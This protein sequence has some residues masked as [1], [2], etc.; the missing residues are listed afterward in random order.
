VWWAAQGPVAWRLARD[1]CVDER[2]LRTLCA[3]TFLGGLARI[4]AAKA[5]GRPHPLFQALTLMELI[6]PPILLDLRRQ[7]ANAAEHGQPGTGE[8]HQ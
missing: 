8:R 6:G 4:A 3:T 5:S 2:R 7:M 1:P